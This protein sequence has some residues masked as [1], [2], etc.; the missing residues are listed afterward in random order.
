MS[1]YSSTQ[2]LHSIQAH[3]HNTVSKHT[4]MAQYPSTQPWHSIQAHSH[5]T[6]TVF[7]PT[8][9]GAQ[10]S[11]TQS[12]RSPSSEQQMG[13]SPGGELSGMITD[14]DP[15]QARRHVKHTL[16]QSGLT[17][18]PLGAESW[19]ALCQASQS[20]FAFAIEADRISPDSVKGQPMLQ[21][22]LL[23]RRLRNV[24]RTRCA[25]VSFP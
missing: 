2:P 21:T 13:H 25:R 10:F 16:E 22:N 18:S 8:T 17:R 24:A 4:A 20:E 7:R 23:I 19:V 9:T 3:S 12:C 5:N 11:P 1:Q 15:T 14:A 6:V